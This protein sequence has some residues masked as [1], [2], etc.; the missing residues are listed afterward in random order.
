M[1]TSVLLAFSFVLPLISAQVP[2]WGPCPEPDVQPGFS[3]KQVQGLCQ[4]VGC[5]SRITTLPTSVG[6][7]RKVKT[8]IITFKK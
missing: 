3:L 6:S 1:K 7:E 2:H 8:C 4:R 5:R